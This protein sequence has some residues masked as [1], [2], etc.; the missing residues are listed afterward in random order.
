ME[1]QSAATAD[2]SGN[3]QEAATGA[4]SMAGH[5]TH[6]ATIVADTDTAVVAN[7]RTLDDLADVASHMDELTATFSV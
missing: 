1:E 6:V 4:A 7:T 5:V 2:I 3:V